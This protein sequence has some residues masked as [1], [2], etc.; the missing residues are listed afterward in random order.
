MA[1]APLTTSQAHG[2]LYASG[3]AHSSGVRAPA[4]G[5][6]DPPVLAVACAQKSRPGYDSL[7]GSEYL[8]TP[9]TLARK[10]QLLATLL[11]ACGARRASSGGGGGGGG[12]GGLVIYSGAGMSTSAG[13]ADY[14][15]CAGDGVVAQQQ[16]QQ[17]Q[18][19]HAPPLLGGPM[20]AK[21]TKTHHVLA[22]LCRAQPALLASWVQQNHDG[23][24]QKAGVPQALMNEIHGS[25]FDPSNPIV[26][27]SGSLRGDL[28]EGLLTAERDADLV[29]AL[30][31]SLCGM[32]ADRLVASCA[33]RA[34]RGGDGG[35]GDDGGDG[36]GGDGG[37]GDGASLGSVVIGLQ[38]TQY[39]DAATLRIFGTLD[40]VFGRLADEMQLQQQHQHQQQGSAADAAPP[41]PATEGVDRFEV[42]YDAE[43]RRLEPGSGAALPT[44]TLD[45]S[46]GAALTITAGPSAGCPAVVTGR[47][48][49]G[50]WRVQLQ[51]HSHKQPAGKKVPPVM[52]LFAET[53]LLGTWWVEAALRGELPQLPVVNQQRT[54][55]DV[56]TPGLPNSE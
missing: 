49:E 56:A 4:L 5:A 35:D 39:D 25:W 34:R 48:I 45:L 32:N 3:A 13:V 37:G 36:G 17:Q 52:R 20:V 41:P 26:R 24:P 31:T 50:H 8:D 40:D 1:T 21:P 9:S 16:Q 22:A 44:T 14:A 11:R 2:W 6:F 30:G 12:G 54:A 43:G 23:L 7:D 42:P 33:A 29:L 18:Q 46:E 53:R 10:V 47:N 19:Q 27:M 55:D 15:T 38:R 51:H 28:F